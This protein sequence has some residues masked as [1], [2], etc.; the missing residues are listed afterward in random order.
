MPDNKVQYLPERLE[1]LSDI[2]ANLWWQADGRARSLFR[3]LDPILWSAAADNAIDML[4]KVDPARLAACAKDP[5][6]LEIYDEVLAAHERLE[7]TAGTWFNDA[8]PD[9]G[10]RP[11]AYFC[12]EFGL[13]ESVPIYSGGLG[14]LAGDHCRAASDL[15][16]PLVG[17]GLLYM[18]GYFDQKLTLEGWQEN[19]DE[20]YDPALTPLERLQAPDGG[21]A[22]ATVTISGREVAIG[23]WKLRVGRSTVHLLDTNLESN[24]PEDRELTARL[25]GGGLELRLKQEWV[26]G[27]GG[28]RVLRALGID[29]G[30]WHA[31]EGHAAFMLFERI[32]E[33]TSTGMSLD[34]AIER[35]RA[36]SIFTTHTP[37]PAGHDSFSEELME[38]FTG[39]FGSEFGFTREAFLR[40]GTHPTIDHNTF[41]MTAAAIRL[42]S[43]VNGVSRRHGRETRRIWQELWPGRD[44]ADVPIGDIT[45]GVHLGSWI[46]GPMSKLL[47]KHL[48]HGEWRHSTDLDVWND[49]LSL[50]SRELWQTHLFLKRRLFDFIREQT[51]RRWREQQTEAVHLVGS[52]TLLNSGALTI[53]FARRFAT[54]KRADLLFRV[55]SRLRRLLTDPW[56]PV[57][58]VFAGKAHP[59]DDEAKRVLQRV[60]SFTRDPAFEGRVAFVEDY[61]LQLGRRLVQGVDLWMNVPR[62]PMEASGTSGMKAALNGV[63]QLSTL[64]GWWAEGFDGEN[65]WTIP[66]ADVD[67]TSEEDEHD[68]DQMFALLE[69]E[70]V[71]LF[72]DRDVH[73]IPLGWT[74]RM[75]NAVR[76]G[77]AQFTAGRMVRDYAERY[78][79][80]ALRAGFE[81]DDPPVHGMPAYDE[82][83]VG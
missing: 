76:V 62:V 34:E 12:A 2:A 56:R 6:F 1:R 67:D 15:G 68:W 35:V 82:A 60:Y 18:K 3:R 13:N 65:G 38:R 28:V 66:L 46:A 58:I 40:L 52:G 19:S 70:I 39:H 10:D 17:V 57:Q 79:A 21:L 51:R 47:D 45:N 11:V 5:G 31:N 63:P 48:G 25:Y 54:Y 81:D 41:H 33:F 29:P 73:A 53:G 71:P 78:Y 23:A 42:S 7:T 69:Q 14:V 74:E 72:Y 80:P 49:V 16:V 8:Y 75:K 59:A 22:L 26:L 36:R 77:G 61:G 44:P 24:H 37:V 9:L 20:T 50:D 27:V 30:A 43:R 83:D 32:R 55:E 4:R 64:D